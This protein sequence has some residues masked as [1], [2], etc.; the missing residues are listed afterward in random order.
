M[1][2][3]LL[4]E[5]LCKIVRDNGH[6]NIADPDLRE[7]EVQIG[8]YVTKIN[9]QRGYSYCRCCGYKIGQGDPAY[10]FT[11]Y[12]NDIQDELDGAL[13]HYGACTW[14]EAHDNEP[15]DRLSEAQLAARRN[16][17]TQKQ[18]RDAK[19]RRRGLNRPGEEPRCGPLT[20]RFVD[21][22]TLRETT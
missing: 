7:G 18:I 21:P 17:A 16:F 19:S 15:P 20:I 14:G 9:A 3:R 6:G 10:Q 8:R 22:A 4:P 12:W 1:Q 5:R 2:V 11:V 13:I